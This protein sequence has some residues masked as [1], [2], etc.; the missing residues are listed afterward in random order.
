MN[1]APAFTVPVIP[2]LRHAAVVG[3]GT[4]GRGIAQ[5]LL[6]AGCEVT[7]IDPLPAAA[8]AARQSLAELF[9]TLGAKGRLTAAP[10]QL[11]ARLSTATDITA[12]ANAEWLFEA[13]PED[14]KLKRELFA[15]AS[16]AAPRAVLA[17]NTSTLSVTAIAAASA[18]PEAVVGMHFFNPPGIMRLV[19]VVPGVLT[20]PEVVA[21]AAE[22]ARRLGRV[23]VIAAD[24]PGFIVNRLARPYYLEA[25]RLHAAGLPV[26]KIDALLRAAGFRQGPFE[27][28]DLIGLDVNLAASLGV[29]RAFFEEPRFRPHPIQQSLV[30]AG[31]LGRKT[32]RG[33]YAYD[34]AGVKLEPDEADAKRTAAATPR[35]L[36]TPWRIAVVG[37]NSAAQQLRRAL[38]AGEPGAIPIMPVALE[39][40]DMIFDARLEP[41]PDEL[42]RLLARG[43]RLAVLCWSR[44]ASLAAGSIGAA[45]YP[46]RIVG[47][48]VV[49]QAPVEST[50]VELM[51]PLSGSGKAVDLESITAGLRSAGID[52]TVVPDRAGGVAFR[53]VA[54]LANEAIGALSEGLA[55]ASDLDSAMRLGVNYP[56][57]PLAWAE[58]IGLSE[59]NHTLRGVH[60]EAPTGSYAP[61]PYL[62]RLAAV[63]AEGLLER[64]DE[65]E[66]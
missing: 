8:I 58:A 51:A 6:Q 53:I 39:D 18:R 11:L 59:L 28:L 55:P 66:S 9:A 1:D 7:L 45:A 20:K 14:L 49:P 30:S 5:L 35:P 54:L 17:T 50:T 52:S 47:F 3:A 34:D 2:T 57:G 36:A 21:A 61:H 26:A 42:G 38:A 63:G 37:D 56:L 4:M 12:A 40:A 65:G 13:A 60:E 64:D 15:S 23:P 32:G 10:E 41:P 27:L 29:Y 44:S 33:F 24:S 22:L 48:S 46:G 31:L 19:E 43:A 62:A 16:K 25:L